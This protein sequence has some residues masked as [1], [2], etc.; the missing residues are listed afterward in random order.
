M[1][2]L[3]KNELNVY[4]CAEARFEAAAA[5]LGLEEG[6][7]NYLRYPNKEITIYIPVSILMVVDFPAPLGPRKPKNC[8]G[9]TVRLTWSTAR[10]WPNR[11]VRFS[12]AIAGAGMS[13]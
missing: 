1:P 7:Y 9:A 4:E 8:P 11:R 2:T 6:L 10:S 12:V 5:K 13:A 3:V